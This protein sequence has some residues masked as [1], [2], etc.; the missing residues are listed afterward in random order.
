MYVLTVPLTGHFPIFL[1]L[2]RPPYSLRQ[3][4][5][6]M[7]LIETLKWPLSIQV[8]GRVKLSEE[9]VLKVIG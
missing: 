7:R 8:K 5:V 3:N 4:N 9:G 1:L 2:L 6:Q